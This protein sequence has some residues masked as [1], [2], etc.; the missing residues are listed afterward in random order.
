[1]SLMGQSRS[2]GDLSSMSGL[3]PVSGLSHVVARGPR[4]ARSRPEQAQQTE[5]LLDD[6]VGAGKHRCRQVEAKRLGGFQIDNEFVF[7]RRLHRQVGRLL[8]LE[9]AIDV[10][11][12]APVLVEEIRSIS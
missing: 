7:G 3:P 11:G 4:S 12:G 2:F 9:N 8:A 5:Q 10:A 1:M 6:L